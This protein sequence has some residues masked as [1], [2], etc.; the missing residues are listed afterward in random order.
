[1]TAANHW[2]FSETAVAELLL[3]IVIREIV[4]KQNLTSIF[5]MLGS[6]GTTP[7]TK[8]SS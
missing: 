1:M 5:S 7:K 3:A 6:I 2:G 8:I 4:V